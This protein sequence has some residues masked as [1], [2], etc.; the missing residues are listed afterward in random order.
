V[1]DKGSMDYK[2]DISRFQRKRAFDTHRI[3]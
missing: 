3:V 2:L 1:I